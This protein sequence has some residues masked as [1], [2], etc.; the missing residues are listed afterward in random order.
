[1]LSRSD[2]SD[3]LV[4]NMAAEHSLSTMWEENP[5]VRTRARVCKSLLYWRDQNKKNTERMITIG[6]NHE[7]LTAMVMYYSSVD[8][9]CIEDV[10]KNVSHFQ[11]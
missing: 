11:L 10:R 3:N 7:V 9:P 6:D 4:Q 8:P 1:M 5:A 2:T